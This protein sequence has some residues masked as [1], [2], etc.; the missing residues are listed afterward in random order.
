MCQ[1]AFAGGDTAKPNP[2]K[3]PGERCKLSQTP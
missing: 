3:G 1:N 2:A